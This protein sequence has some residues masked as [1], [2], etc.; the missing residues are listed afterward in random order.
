MALKEMFRQVGDL[1]MSQRG[2]AE[3]GLI[4]RHL[5]MPNDVADT[6]N[7]LRFLAVEISPRTHVNVMDQYRPC[8]RAESDPRI[9]RRTMRSEFDR[10][11]TWVR[12][13]G[14]MRLDKRVSWYV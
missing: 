10:A 11:L 3:R 14:L 9:S 2:I 13:A 5:V 12:E 8:Y 1:T 7:I 4:V 6:E